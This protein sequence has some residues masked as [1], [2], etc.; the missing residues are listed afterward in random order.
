MSLLPTTLQP[1]GDPIG[2]VDEQG[3]VIPEKN[4]WLLL[5]NLCQNVLGIGGSAGSP[6]SLP[7]SALT[8]L[9]S[10]DADAA[11][12]DA[13]NLRIPISS[14][15]AQ[16]GFSADIFV[17]DLAVLTSKV[18]NALL[19]AQDGLLSAD[20]GSTPGLA[21]PSAVVGLAAVNG[22]ATTAMRSDGAPALSQAIAPTWTAQ[23][24]FTPGTSTTAIIVNTTVN[25]VG[26]SVR[27]G[28]GSGAIIEACGD[29]SGTGNGLSMSQSSVGAGQIN[30]NFN[31]SLSFKVNGTVRMT[32]NASGTVTFISAI[33]VNGNA[34]PAQ[35]TGWGTPVG[36]A[37]I[38]NYNITDAGGANSN[39]NKAVAQI[40]ADLKAFGLYGA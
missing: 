15:A 12:A 13:V 6:V 19:L 38:N 3:N 7:V 27:S 5:Y 1:P 4:F 20:I 33:G 30:L 8:E 34:P 29:G 31:A 2:K 11:D 36:N 40:I 32:I 18:N 10:L 39:T 23:H 14:L 22:V 28:A 21:S 16:Q 9:A 35:V 17:G 26:L 24:V 25:N 37:V